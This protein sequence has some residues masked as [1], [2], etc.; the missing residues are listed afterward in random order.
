M[1]KPCDIYFNRSKSVAGS[2]L[3]KLLLF[4]I[5]LKFPGRR[6]TCVTPSI[7]LW[8]GRMGEWP[9]G[10][11][12]SSGIASC[13]V[14]V[15]LPNR[16]G[17]FSRSAEKGIRY[18][19]SVGRR[20][21]HID[22]SGRLTRMP[23]GIRTS[24]SWSQSMYRI[25]WWKGRGNHPFRANIVHGN[26]NILFTSEGYSTK[27]KLM[28]TITNMSD[29]CGIPIIERDLSKDEPKRKKVDSR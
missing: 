3:D 18:L 11:P 5:G 21:C 6:I 9:P 2:D 15:F 7:E 27:Q 20:V 16:D 12:Y 4:A 8:R 24:R 23:L 22:R 28:Q 17:T 29:K 10:S 13:G 14:G 19:K 26:G 1:H 25:E